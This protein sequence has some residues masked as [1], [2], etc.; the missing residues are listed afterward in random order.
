MKYG[1]LV[2]ELKV[3]Y[4]MQQLINEHGM[5]YVGGLLLFISFFIQGIFFR[6]YLKYIKQFPYVKDDLNKYSLA[7]NFPI[8]GFITRTAGVGIIFG[9]IIGII[10]WGITAVISTIFTNGSNNSFTLFIVDYHYL[11]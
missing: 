6:I 3:L 11:I 8:V 10:I 5:L 2:N 9:G 4:N 1:D 7:K